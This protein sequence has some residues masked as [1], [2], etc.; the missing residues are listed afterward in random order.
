MWKVYW[1]TIPVDSNVQKRGIALHSKCVL[2]RET[3][4]GDTRA[5]LGPLR[6]AQ[7]LWTQ[8]APKIQK[9]MQ[10]QSIDHLL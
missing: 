4:K 8:F 9:T 5:S 6:Y 3:S 1:G 7:T 2:L 10:I